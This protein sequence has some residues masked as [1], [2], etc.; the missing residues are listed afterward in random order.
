MTIRAGAFV[1]HISCR[2]WIML[3]NGI[4][5][6]NLGVHATK[7]WGISILLHHHPWSQNDGTCGRMNAGNPALIDENCR[8]EGL[9]TKVGNQICQCVLYPSGGFNIFWN[10]GRELAHASDNPE[11]VGSSGWPWHDAQKARCRSAMNNA[12]YKR[13]D[14]VPRLIRLLPL[15]PEV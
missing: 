1:F 10:P 13:V 8:M 3:Y 12:L 6:W 5:L 15:V 9:L 14:Q 7:G 2:H 4:Y 11:T